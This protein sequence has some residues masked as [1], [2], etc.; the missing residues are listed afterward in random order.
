MAGGRINH[1]IFKDAKQLPHSL[2]S[3][4][5][6]DFSKDLY[7]VSGTVRYT[8]PNSISDLFQVDIKVPA[9]YPYG[10][11]ILYES[12]GR[13]PFKTERHFNHDG[14]CCV[15]VPAVVEREAR[16]GLSLARYVERFAVP[17]FAN[18]I[19]YD[20]T[21]KFLKERSHGDA[22]I[23]EH[24]EAIL[25][26]SNLKELSI[27]FAFY[28]KGSKIGRNDQCF[29]GSVKKYKHCHLRGILELRRYYTMDELKAL[30]SREI[31]W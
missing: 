5:I 17:F 25:Y 14:S 6:A 4:Y 22:G 3:L 30:Y 28:S 1:R 7:T 27:I 24:V 2:G 16:K 15:E 21:G 8:P 11:P 10:V 13:Y 19:Y 12:G 23:R 29:C 20:H 9:N 31:L 18:Q 26:T